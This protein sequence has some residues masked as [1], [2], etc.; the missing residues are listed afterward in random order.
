MILPAPPSSC[1]LSC[2]PVCT[3]SAVC[4]QGTGLCVDPNSFT[5]VI[6]VTSSPAAPPSSDSS[7]II[8]VA[9][10][11]PVVVVAGVIAALV[12][13]YVTA[14]QS[15]TTTEEMRHELKEKELSNLNRP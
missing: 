5:G 13:K 4:D 14:K 7:W 11:V 8:I 3:G 1:Q 9:V 12:I 2:S 6:G 10:V 15:V